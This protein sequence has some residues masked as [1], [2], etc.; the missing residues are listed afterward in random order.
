MKSART[1][2]NCRTK[3]KRIQV[4]VS[5]Q[6]YKLIEMVLKD[7]ENENN[8]ISEMIRVFLKEK[9]EEKLRND[10]EL[11]AKVRETLM[12]DFIGSK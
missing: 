11:A 7:E 9:V 1:K 3:S 10:E 5:E 6:E 4:R 12:S 8:N 2:V